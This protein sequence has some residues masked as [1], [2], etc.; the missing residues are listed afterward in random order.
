M[1]LQMIHA[2]IL[3]VAQGRGKMRSMSKISAGT[4]VSVK[5]SD[6]TFIIPVLYF[7]VMIA[8]DLK[9]GYYSIPVL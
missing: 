4:V 8:D 5:L 1:V 9:L 6:K 2:V 7:P 3:R